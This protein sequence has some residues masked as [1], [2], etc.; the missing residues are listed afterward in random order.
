[1]VS[2][3]HKKHG[4]DSKQVLDPEQWLQSL[5]KDHSTNEVEIIRRACDIA[6]NAHAGQLRAS[7][8]PFFLHSLAV[9]NI[10][11]DLHMDYET[12]AAAILHDVAEDTEM[13][14]DDIKDTFGDNIS[15][16]VDG[17]TKMELINTFRPEEGDHKQQQ[18]Q[19]ETLRKML[20][21][22]AEDVRVVM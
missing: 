1:M 12:L 14:L 8:E 6:R 9:A 18:A 2:I 3:Q 13:T 15:R 4:T 21:A 20:L 22:M 16:L 11:T 5:Q 19:V 17:V 7:G 10:L